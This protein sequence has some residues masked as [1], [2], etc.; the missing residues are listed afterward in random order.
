MFTVTLKILVLSTNQIIHMQLKQN[1][2]QLMIQNKNI[3]LRIL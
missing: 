2:A 1:N 3:G